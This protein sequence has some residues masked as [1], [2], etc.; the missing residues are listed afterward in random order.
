ME[1]PNFLM[2]IFRELSTFTV[3][4]TFSPAV[5]GARSANLVIRDSAPG[6]PQTAGLSGVGVAAPLASIST[7]ALSFG[8]ENLGVVSAPQFVTVNDTGTAPLSGLSGA[9]TRI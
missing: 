1:R 9:I 4:V 7:A 6:S 2:G 3:T 8:N 5:A